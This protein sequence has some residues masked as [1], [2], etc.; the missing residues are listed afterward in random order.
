MRRASVAGEG[1][2]VGAGGGV[3][4]H[5]GGSDGGGEPVAVHDGVVSGAQQG[6]VSQIR[7][8]AVEPVPDV[9]QLVQ[10][11]GMSQEGKLQCRSRS[12][13]VR[14]WAGLNSRSARP[15][16]STSLWVPSR[17]GMMA[18]SQ[19]IRRAVSGAS[20]VPA[21]R[22]PRVVAA[23]TRSVRSVRLMVSSRVAL[24]PPAPIPASTACIVCA[25]SGSNRSRRRVGVDRRRLPRRSLARC[26]R[27]IASRSVTSCRRSPRRSR[28]SVP[29]PVGRGSTASRS[30]SS[31]ARSAVGRRVHR[32]SAGADGVAAEAGSADGSH[33]CRWPGAGR[34]RGRL[35]VDRVCPRGGGM[36]AER[37]GGFGGGGDPPAYLDQ[38][39]PAPLRCR[40]RVSG[41]ARVPG[42][43]QRPD[44]GL[45]DGLGFDVEAQQVLPHPVIDTPGVRQRHL[46]GGAVLLVL[47]LAGGAVVGQQPR[48]QLRTSRAP[49]STPIS[50]SPASTSGSAS[51][52]I[53]PRSLSNSDT[54]TSATGTDSSPASTASLTGARIG[55]ASC[56]TH[57][58]D[59]PR[60]APAGQRRRMPGDPCRRRGA[61][62]GGH[63]TTLHRLR[64]HRDP[65]G[66]RQRHHLIQL[67]HQP[68]QVRSTRLPEQL[69]QLP[70]HLDRCGQTIP[71]V[72]ERHAPLVRTP[73]T[74][75]SHGRTSHRASRSSPAPHRVGVRPWQ[76]RYLRPLTPLPAESVCPPYRC[77]T[78]RS[79]FLHICLSAVGA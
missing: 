77:I 17:T 23:P 52:M 58:A 24:A 12:S 51:A 14:A 21:S 13:T 39:L 18:A 64:G 79:H 63:L 38:R 9:V 35:G 68:A 30:R 3:P 16:S 6:G 47:Q 44:R 73:R 65:A 7:A 70:K 45:Q 78:N 55:R 67:G 27:S 4:D 33:Q 15:R 19:A 11:P 75:P 49:S 20:R 36:A 54:T 22:L 2:V 42:C 53:R 1:A 56:S 10:N 74:P 29:A 26:L 66:P 8:T 37:A 46:G 59:L 62:R 57:L 50:T 61:L 5:A 34:P 31:A 28:R 40:A 76:E 72:G 25:S 43:G 32:P 71:Y 41:P 69:R 48:T 60:P